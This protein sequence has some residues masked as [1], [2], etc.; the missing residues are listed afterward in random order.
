MTI[1]T[2]L[3]DDSPRVQAAID[4]LLDATQRFSS[5]AFASSLGKE[6]MVLTDIIASHAL[7]IRIFTLNTGKL[8][9]ETLALLEATRARYRISIEAFEPDR[10]H[11]TALAQTQSESA[12]YEGIAARKACCNTRKIEPLQ[13]AL[14]GATAWI[15]GQR[16]AQSVTRATLAIEENDAAHQM[17][18][19]NPLAHW[20]DAEIDEYLRRRLVPINALHARGFPSIGCAPCTR[21]IA[22]G[23][24]ERAGRWWWEN[25]EQKECG[26]HNNPR[27]ALPPIISRSPL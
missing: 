8:H 17:A 14:R 15:T 20:S 11:L 16:R 18:K 19:L 27:R 7:P 23:E 6:D 25:P 12:I 24:D 4:C 10:N 3:A 26:L 5:V 13:R 1:K 21:A 9:P 2:P 22:P